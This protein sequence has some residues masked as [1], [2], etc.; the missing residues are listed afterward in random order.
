M[1][2]LIVISVILATVAVIALRANAF[3]RT[4]PYEYRVDVIL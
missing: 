1:G 2:S 4:N 3:L